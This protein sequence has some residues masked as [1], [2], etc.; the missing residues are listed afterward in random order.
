MSECLYAE[1]LLTTEKIHVSVLCPAF[2]RTRLAESVRNKP[3][4]VLADPAASFGFHDT[5]KHV[6]EEGTP[7]E[8]IARAMIKA[9]RDNRFWILTHP[10][11]DGGI[12]DRFESMLSRTNP[13]LRDLRPE[14]TRLA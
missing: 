13:P 8:D 6:V 14:S 4:G 3:E 10:Q 2:A 1:L 5:L 7:P 12:R 9:V 11:L